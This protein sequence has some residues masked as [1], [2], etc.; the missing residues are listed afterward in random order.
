MAIVGVFVAICIGSQFTIAAG[1]GG[2]IPI[3]VAL[4]AFSGILM[5]TSRF[6]KALGVLL[7]IF[8]LIGISTLNKRQMTWKLVPREIP[9]EYQ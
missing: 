1:P 4:A 8:S 6:L 5:L 2:D 3:F 9:T 7:L